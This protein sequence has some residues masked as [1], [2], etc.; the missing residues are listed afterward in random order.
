M[1]AIALIALAAALAAI[2]AKPTTLAGL[3]WERRILLV[4]AP[5]AGDP[6]VAAQ[7]RV[8][9]EIKGSGDDRDLVLVEVLG[10]TVR[11]TADSASDVRRVFGLPADKFVVLL[12]GKDG[13]EKRRSTTPLSAA[14]LTGTIDAMPMRRSG[15]R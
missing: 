10:D 1:P 11:G 4:S 2:P 15:E 6:E 9:A 7:G 8:F 12:I 14:T 5:V 3:R 13:G